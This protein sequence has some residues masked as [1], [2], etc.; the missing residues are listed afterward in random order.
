MEKRE[1]WRGIF[2]ST[3]ELEGL[4]MLH[5]ISWEGYL[6]GM[7]LVLGVIYLYVFF[8]YYPKERKAVWRMVMGR[9]SGKR[10][11]DM[12]EEVREQDEREKKEEEQEQ[13]EGK[14]EKKEEP[15]EEEEKINIKTS[16]CSW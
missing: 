8:R 14:G 16:R 5:G 10:G 12:Q 9:A 2:V 3:K 11:E 15:K 7:W 6:K 4:C 13:D 1:P